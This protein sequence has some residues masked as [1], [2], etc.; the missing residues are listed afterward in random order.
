[1]RFLR[2]SLI[3]LF[4][5]GLT[6]GIL[7]YAGQMV[8][9]A[10]ETRM[11]DAPRNTERRERVFAV[12]TV[13]AEEQSLSP[14]LIAFGEVQSRRT[15]EIR[16]KTGG[17]ITEL[18]GDF[19]EGGTVEAG[20]V[21]ARIDPADAQ[22]ALARAHAD[23]ADARA[24]TLEAD[25][26]LVIA[27][28]DLTAARAQADLRARAFERQKDLET[29]GVGTAT[30]VEVAELAAA[31]ARQSVLSSR[32]AEA[33]AE[34]RVDQA[35]TRLNRAEIAL[36]EAERRLADTVIKAGFSGRLSAVNVVTG[37]VV[38][39]NE[40][41]AD[42]IDADALEV[43]FRIS[44]AQYSRLLGDDG[45]LIAAP[46]TIALEAF[47]MTLNATGVITRDSAAVG[48]GQTGRLLFARIDSTNGLKPGDFVTVSVQEP[49]LEHV[50]RLPASALG[51]DGQVLV[52]G[53]EARLE[54][55]PVTLLR[56]QGDDILV[57][58]D[59][60]AGREVVAQRAP[61]L[62]SGIK[63]RVINS[64][65]D[66]DPAAR[67]EASLM[68]ELTEARRAS[69]IAFIKADSTLSDADRARMIARLSQ[70]RVPAGMVRQLETRMGG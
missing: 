41:L 36:A 17:T 4:L 59:G 28:D 20:Q 21:L 3:G 56:R 13:L 35:A 67:E 24:E 49:V 30:A 11:S 39:I 42:L 47:G 37:G 18:A 19:I 70:A 12:N 65:D 38:A 62:G 52:L 69:L 57:R 22:S 66:D 25:R 8:F 29:R 33:L 2:H 44:T 64:G 15:L 46:V 50:V 43:A 48:A 55:L 9:S 31:Q 34:A 51:P 54:A 27:R 1:M 45:R 58:G 10:V 40:K 53:P 7:A 68:L 26:A 63:V 32:Q 16:A 61:V 23:L 60:L 14:V 5:F 6:A